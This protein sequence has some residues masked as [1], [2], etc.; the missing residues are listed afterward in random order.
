MTPCISNLRHPT[1]KL[2]RTKKILLPLPFDL[3]PG[4]MPR[5]HRST[6]CGVCLHRQQ[7]WQARCWAMASPC[8][9]ASSPTLKCGPPYLFLYFLWIVCVHSLL[10]CTIYFDLLPKCIGGSDTV[11]S[12]LAA[13]YLFWVFSLFLQFLLFSNYIK[14]FCIIILGVCIGC[15][16]SGSTPDR[17]G[18]DCYNQEDFF[19]KNGFGTAAPRMSWV[20][21]STPLNPLCSLD[22]SSTITGQIELSS[23]FNF[24]PE[25]VLS[26]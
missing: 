4:M 2:R 15:S 22:V 17:K 18:T 23:K 3:K 13:L 19:I 7:C 24:S 25:E 5:R 26:C 11:D 12:T 16:S 9:R 20:P 8:Q 14:L 6:T 1:L 21:L 10:Y